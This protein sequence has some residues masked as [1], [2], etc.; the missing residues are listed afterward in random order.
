VRV[1]SAA[2]PRSETCAKTQRAFVLPL[3]M[4]PSSAHAYRKPFALRVSP[5]W[6]D[7]CGFSLVEV[8]IAIGIAGGALAVLLALLSGLLR[9]T[10]DN[11]DLQTAL[12]LCAA[13]EARLYEDMG[14]SFPGAL[15]AARAAR[16]YV[17]D[18]EGAHLRGE[19]ED[20]S[21]SLPPPHFYIEI[22]PFSAAPLAYEA[23]RAVLPLQVRAA[24]VA[25]SGQAGNAQSTEFVLSL[26]PP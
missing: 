25:N 4:T 3:A 1:T 15:G 19:L 10:D 21:S 14:G 26:T 5:A 18:K 12:R 24:V 22:K 16:V 6:R 23:G 9:A 7:T 8:L 17:A 11:A 2:A 13:I 20:G